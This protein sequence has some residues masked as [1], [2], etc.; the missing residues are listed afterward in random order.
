MN[1]KIITIIFLIFLSFLLGRFT[2]PKTLEIEKEY[3]SIS[4]CDE[5]VSK[6]DQKVEPFVGEIAA[7]NFD[8]LPEAKLFQSTI[9]EQSSEGPNFAGHY[10]VGNVARRFFDIFADFKVPD[11]RDQRQKMEFIVNEANANLSSSD[12]IP[13]QDWLK[14]YKLINEFSHNYDPMSTIEHKDKSESQ[15]AIELLL[16]IV[17]RSDSKHY[18]IL[19][20]SV[21]E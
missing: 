10:T 2:T 17:K 21:S 20:K 6:V 11:S 8:S 19:E 5:I 7:V 13:E 4:I 12:V 18:E 16:K 9:T 15:N 14:A 1:R 3:T